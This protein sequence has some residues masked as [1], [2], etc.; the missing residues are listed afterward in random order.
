MSWKHFLFVCDNPFFPEKVL[1]IGESAEDRAQSHSRIEKSSPGDQEKRQKA[2]QY[3]MTD[4]LEIKMGQHIQSDVTSQAKNR[5]E[6]HARSGGTCKRT[7]NN[8]SIET[9]PLLTPGP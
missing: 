9:Q 8:V 4:L 7:N 5:C 3:F 1:E 2:E 6:D